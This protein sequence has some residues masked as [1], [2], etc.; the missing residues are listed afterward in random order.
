MKARMVLIC[1]LTIDVESE[2]QEHQVNG[3]RVVRLP[4]NN[5]Q[6][7]VQFC[8]LANPRYVDSAPE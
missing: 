4:L 2:Q 8:L 1:D 5:P 7:P 6:Y 3:M